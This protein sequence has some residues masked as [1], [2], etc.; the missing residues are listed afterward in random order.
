MSFDAIRF[1]LYEFF[2]CFS[3]G[4]F[5]HDLHCAVSKVTCPKPAK[6]VFGLFVPDQP[7]FNGLLVKIGGRPGTGH[8]MLWIHVIPPW[9]I[10]IGGF[11]LWA[12]LR[13]AHALT[14]K[15][16]M[17]APRAPKARY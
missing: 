8:M 6:S 4:R 10:P 3:I 12:G 17:P 15:P 13:M 1:G 9:T 11:A 2:I 7:V 16:H 14:W 5:Y